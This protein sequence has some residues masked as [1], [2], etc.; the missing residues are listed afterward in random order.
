MYSFAP[1]RGLSERTERSSGARNKSVPLLLLSLEAKLR[2]G[3]LLGPVCPCTRHF[4]LIKSP[5]SDVIVSKGRCGWTV[6]RN[7]RI[8][9][10]IVI[11]TT[12]SAATRSHQWVAEK[13]ARKNGWALPFRCGFGFVSLDLPYSST[14]FRRT[15]KDRNRCCSIRG[16]VRRRPPWLPVCAPPFS[17]RNENE[18]RTALDTRSP[19]RRTLR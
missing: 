12:P 4:L 14:A 13:I 10:G 3:G 8:G 1:A 16:T 18:L 6:E 19:R 9:A 5:D 11:A 7:D 17:T 15:A 2:L